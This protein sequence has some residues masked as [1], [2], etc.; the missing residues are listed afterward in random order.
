MFFVF[1]MG[2]THFMAMKQWGQPCDLVSDYPMVK[3]SKNWPNWHIY[4]NPIIY[5]YIY[6][7]VTAMVKTMVCCTCHSNQSMFFH[8]NMKM[9]PTATGFILGSLI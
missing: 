1:S 7:V 5:I 6:L 3:Q 9:P 2:D 4:R 8:P